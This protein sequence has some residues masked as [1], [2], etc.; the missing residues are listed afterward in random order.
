MEGEVYPKRLNGL[1]NPFGQKTSPNKHRIF[2]K[3]H[4]L[5]KKRK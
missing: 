1:S 3:K 4:F 5:D 2:F